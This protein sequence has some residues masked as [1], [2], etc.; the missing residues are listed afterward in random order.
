MRILMALCS[1]LHS[2]LDTPWQTPFTGRFVSTLLVNSSG[3]SLQI[4][5][6]SDCARQV[7]TIFRD[8]FSRFE[9]N[10]TFRAGC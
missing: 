6:H 10:A 4:M 5:N 8:V 1:R 2:R 9:I 3:D 7:N